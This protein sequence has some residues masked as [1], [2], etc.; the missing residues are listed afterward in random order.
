MKIISSYLYIIFSQ[1]WI[2]SWW[3]KVVLNISNHSLPVGQS[4]CNIQFQSNLK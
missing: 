3:D 2:I 1:L 4:Y